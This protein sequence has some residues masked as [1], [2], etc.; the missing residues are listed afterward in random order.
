ML[1]TLRKPLIQELL[2][3]P[4]ALRRHLVL[5]VFGVIFIALLAQLRIDIGPVPITGQTFA[6]LLLA[7]VYG[8]N[9]SV[10]TVT[11]YLMVGALGL[12]VFQGFTYGLSVLKGATAGY[13]FGFIIAVVLVG[14]LAQRGWDRNFFSAALIMFLGN[15]LIYIPG[16]LWLSHLFPEWSWQTTLANGFIPFIWGDIIKLLFAAALLPLAWKLLGKTD[17]S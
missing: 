17:E 8:L 16:L 15:A 14:Y 12:P 9:L 13:L 7:A 10:L 2:F 4:N 11:C 3:I 5:V 6:I 1:Q